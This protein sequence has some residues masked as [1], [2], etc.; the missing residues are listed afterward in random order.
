MGKCNN[1]FPEVK[2]GV[3]SQMP[4]W[5]RVP[6]SRGLLGRESLLLFPTTLKHPSS[7]QCPLRLEKLGMGRK[8]GDRSC[9][10]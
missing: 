4:I 10:V 8:S 3:L 7:C 6:Q 9:H 5:P 1:K 2:S